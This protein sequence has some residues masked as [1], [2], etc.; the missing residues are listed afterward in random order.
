MMKLADIG[1]KGEA[2][3][4]GQLVGSVSVDVTAY[5]ARDDAFGE[6]KKAMRADPDF[7]FICAGN[8]KCIVSTLIGKE[9]PSR[10]SFW[11]SP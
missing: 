2:K 6:A 5:K 8:A 1:C 3:G 7:V 10:A 4:K 11:S 9:W